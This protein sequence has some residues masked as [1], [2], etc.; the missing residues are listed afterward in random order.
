MQR[1]TKKLFPCLVCLSQGCDGDSQSQVP[2]A[3]LHVSIT[4]CCPCAC[5]AGLARVNKRVDTVPYM[6]TCRASNSIRTTGEELGGGTDKAHAGGLG[7]QCQSISDSWNRIRV[8]GNGASTFPWGRVRHAEQILSWVK[9]S[10]QQGVRQPS[11]SVLPAFLVPH[12]SFS[13][14]VAQL[15]WWV[16]WPLNSRKWCWGGK[17]QWSPRFGAPPLS[18]CGAFITSSRK[19]G[20]KGGKKPG[21][22]GHFSRPSHAIFA[23]GKAADPERKWGHTS[24]PLGLLSSKEGRG[25]SN[26]RSINRSC[27]REDRSV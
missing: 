12:L 4:P 5:L 24:G 6:G 20:D 2:S 15:I 8:P 11:T 23:L 3:T 27:S 1:H 10:R 25:T 13:L 21:C 19:A 26:T 9:V 17:A 16:Q 22:I 7:K 18:V 14:G